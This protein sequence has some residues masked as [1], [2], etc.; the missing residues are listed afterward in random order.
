MTREQRGP[1][2][3]VS[4]LDEHASCAPGAAIALPTDSSHHIK[5]V[6]RL[7]QA[8]AIELAD[9]STGK[10][11][12]GVIDSLS[13][14]VNVRIIN[15]LEPVT[16]KSPPIVLLCALCKGPKND[17]ICDWATELGGAQII[18]WQAARSVVKLHDSNDARAKESRLNKI[19]L[20]AA[21]QSR[22]AK[23]PKITVTTSLSL[24]LAATKEIGDIEP[25]KV[26]CSLSEGAASI[27]AVLS[28]GH[29]YSSVHIAIGPEGD[30]TSEEE[31]LLVE[32]GFVRASLGSSVLRSEL[33][34]V[35]AMVAVKENLTCD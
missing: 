34:V 6:L 2:I 9:P 32:S 21:Q 7:R 1:R 16:S 5:D 20:S 3:F 4:G 29:D 10:V 28:T 12:K 27:R 11:Y 19:A 14:G 23:P 33:A 35:T 8:D 15:D 30:L 24:A 18:F 31:N 22:Q 13:T 26:V 25:C 17:L